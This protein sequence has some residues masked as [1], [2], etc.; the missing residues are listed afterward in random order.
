MSVTSQG[1]KKRGK[2]IYGI[3]EHGGLALNPSIDASHGSPSIARS[4]PS[5]ESDLQRAIV[6]ENRVI[7]E[8]LAQQEQDLAEQR[9]IIE[10]M[11]AFMQ[12]H[13]PSTSSPDPSSLSR[14]LFRDSPNEGNS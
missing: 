14:S 6:E 4:H 1:R 2:R 9:Q 13:Q 7:K 12:Q 10:Q 5:T 11:R 3:G 8:K